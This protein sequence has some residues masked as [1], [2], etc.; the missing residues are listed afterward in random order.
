MKTLM[1]YH[2]SDL[3]S[4]HSTVTGGQAIDYGFLYLHTAKIANNLW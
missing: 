2:V 1:V 3:L 4:T